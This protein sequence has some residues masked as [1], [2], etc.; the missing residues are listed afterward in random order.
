MGTWLETRPLL[1]GGGGA[2]S[3]LP[4]QV[5]RGEGVTIEMTFLATDSQQ[6]LRDETNGRSLVL[7]L[8][9]GDWKALGVVLH[10]VC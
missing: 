4:K 2:S 3:A 8:P 1:L 7:L 10:L 5:G 6:R 9:N